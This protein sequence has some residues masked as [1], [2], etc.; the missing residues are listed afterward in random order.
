MNPFGGNVE[1]YFLPFE[2]H[3]HFYGG[4]IERLLS[5]V[6]SKAVTGQTL[7]DAVRLFDKFE[8]PPPQ[9]TALTRALKQGE[10]GPH[11]V[12]T[13]GIHIGIKNRLALVKMMF[14]KEENLGSKRIA[15]MLDKSFFDTTFWMLWATA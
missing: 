13:K 7:M 2:C 4:N 10:E 8:Q 14:D 12:Y 6:P 1:G 3:P 9:T 15:D 11:I 5:L